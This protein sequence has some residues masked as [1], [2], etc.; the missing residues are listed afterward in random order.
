MEREMSIPPTLQ[1]ECG[2][3]Y[4]YPPHPSPQYTDLTDRIT[5]SV[6]E[7][8]KKQIA[9]IFFLGNRRRR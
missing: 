2:S 3:L 4:L 5:F 7:G 1:L 6:V 9:V 8:K